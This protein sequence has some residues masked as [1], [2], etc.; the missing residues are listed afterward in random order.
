MTQSLQ[1]TFEL[2]FYFFSFSYTEQLQVV[3]FQ[4]CV[5]LKRNDCPWDK[6]TK[7]Y[8]W[9]FSTKTIF[10]TGYWV[11]FRKKFLGMCLPHVDNLIFY[12]CWKERTPDSWKS[13][14]WK[15]NK[16]RHEDLE[17]PSSTLHH[18]SGSVLT[19][20]CTAIMR[21]LQCTPTVRRVKDFCGEALNCKA[22]KRGKIEL[23]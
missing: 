11:F 18:T 23:L 2:D 9:L 14:G 3:V 12:F 22:R 5:C 17:M 4:T 21:L 6:T 19:P 8:C 13:L 1:C 10:T 16:T 7:H 15:Q 20:K